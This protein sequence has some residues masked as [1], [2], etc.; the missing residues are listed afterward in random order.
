M[1]ILFYCEATKSTGIGHLARCYN[2]ADF[3]KE[4]YKIDV[5]ITGNL[6]LAFIPNKYNKYLDEKYDIKGNNYDAI[7]FDSYSEKEYNKIDDLNKIKISID[8]VEVF[9]YQNW[10]LTINFRFKESYKKYKSKKQVTGLDYFPVNNFFTEIRKNYK[11]SREIRN[12]FYYF[13]ETQILEID[14]KTEKTLEKFN[15]KYNF[16]IRTPVQNNLYESINGDNFELLFSN[17]DVIIHGGG[18][19]KYESAYSKKF[20]LAYSLNSLQK[21]DTEFLSKYNLVRDMGKFQSFHDSLISSIDFLDNQLTQ[22]DIKKFEN[23]SNKLFSNKSLKNI[24]EEIIKV[25]V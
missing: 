10:D 16:F 25:V 12:L 3:I 19:T 2:L 7:V 8:D 15:D 4:N 21:S 17:S 9:D 20:N 6:D 14:S 11:N 18:L 5:V 24:S 23:N 13:G 22:S 1:K